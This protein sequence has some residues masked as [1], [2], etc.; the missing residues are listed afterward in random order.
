MHIRP[1]SFSELLRRSLNCDPGLLQAVLSEN[2]QE[3]LIVSVSDSTNIARFALRQCV[4][5]NDKCKGR[6]HPRPRAD[7][8][9]ERLSSLDARTSSRIKAVLDAL[10]E[11]TPVYSQWW[12]SGRAYSSLLAL[13]QEIQP[14]RGQVAF[15]G[16][17]TM[18]ALFS[19]SSG[20][21][22]TVLDID[23]H[24]L[25]CLSGH[26]SPGTQLVPYDANNEPDTT[27]IEQFGMVFVDP[28]WGRTLLRLFMHRAADLVCPGGTVV[29]SFP[30]CL[31]RPGTAQEIHILLSEARELGL[32][33]RERIVNGTEYGIPTFEREAYSMQGIEI[34]SEWRRG[35]LFLFQKSFRRVERNSVPLTGASPAWQQFPQGK[36][37]L[38]LQRALNGVGTAPALRPLPGS[39]AFRCLTTSSRSSV[40]QNASLVST[41]NGVAMAEGVAELARILPDYLA[42]IAGTHQ[43]DGPACGMPETNLIAALHSMLLDKCG[44]SA[45]E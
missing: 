31:T 41:Q 20:N 14:V 24:V 38:F 17:P 37:R 5:P 4:A 21:V 2:V 35:D 45:G 25:R 15:L 42:E 10:P 1:M 32:D 8:R 16:S 44:R 39:T 22:V 13:L 26:Y 33:L 11:P 9:L 12:F 29:I 7:Y 43:H 3:G 36:H 40:M 6:W 27:L 18:A 23:A 19:Q 28:P 30:Q 34:D